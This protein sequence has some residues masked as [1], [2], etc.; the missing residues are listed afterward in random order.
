M[1][2]AARTNHDRHAVLDSTITALLPLALPPHASEPSLFLDGILPFA[3]IFNELETTWGSLE[4]CAPSDDKHV[5]E[6]RTSLAE[7]SMAQLRMDLRRSERFEQDVQHLCLLT[8]RDRASVD[9]RQTQKIA[10]VASLSRRLKACV[11]TPHRLIAHIYVWYMAVLSGGRYLQ[12]TLNSVDPS[13]W[14]HKASNEVAGFSF[15]ESDQA[16]RATLKAQLARWDA[17]LNEDERAEMVE[18]THVIYDLV[19]DLVE[20]LK[21]Q[22]PNHVAAANTNGGEKVDAGEKQREALHASKV[23]NPRPSMSTIPLSSGPKISWMGNGWR[24]WVLSWLKV[25]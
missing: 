6:V 1:D 3:Q 17:V 19:I 7:S 25:R 10:P 15:L 21:G 18:E 20:T 5:E 24:D 22:A 16:L 2:E 11:D 8:G 12:R 9:G 23:G 14:G 4:D 13:F